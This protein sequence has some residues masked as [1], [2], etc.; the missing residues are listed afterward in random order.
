MKQRIAN[1]CMFDKEMYSRHGNSLETDHL[2]ETIIGSTRESEH[3]NQ[4]MDAYSFTG[5]VSTAMIIPMM[6]SP[7]IGPV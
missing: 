4:K 2:V 6:S 3:Q 1:N 5:G 7:I